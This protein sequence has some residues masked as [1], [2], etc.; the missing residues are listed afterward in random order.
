MPAQ[1]LLVLGGSA[2]WSNCHLQHTS[3]NLRFYLVVFLSKTSKQSKSCFV[4]TS[5]RPHPRSEGPRVRPGYIF[6]T[7]RNASFMLSPVLPFFDSHALDDLNG[8]PIKL[9]TLPS[10]TVCNLLGINSATNIGVLQTFMFKLCGKE[11]AASFAAATANEIS[12]M[13]E[14]RLTFCASSLR[15]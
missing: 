14:Q 4:T 8:W 5:L 9:S 7:T 12:R 3:A 13:K 1:L 6:L 10:K 11:K 15:N 2:G